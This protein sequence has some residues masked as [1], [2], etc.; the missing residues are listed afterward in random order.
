LLDLNDVAFMK[1][2]REKRPLFFGRLAE[3]AE[4]KMKKRREGGW[5]GE[6]GQI[7]RRTTGSRGGEKAL[8]RR[9]ANN[10]ECEIFFWCGELGERSFSFAGC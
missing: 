9:R 3:E 10:G 8:G 6:I 4:T 1:E 7:N 5:M 2:R